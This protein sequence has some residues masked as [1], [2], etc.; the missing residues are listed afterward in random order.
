MLGGRHRRAD[1]APDPLGRPRH[2]GQ[3]EVGQQLDGGGHQEVV[4]TE[5][6]RAQ[7]AHPE[8]RRFD[9]DG[10]VGGLDVAPGAAS[11]ISSDL[12]SA[13]ST[14]ASTTRTAATPIAPQPSQTAS[15]VASAAPAP[16]SATAVATGAA[17]AWTSATG[18]SACAARRT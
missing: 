8:H 3:V 1:R 9:G 7:L 14:T 4:G 15:S 5:S 12:S 13:T 6:D 17:T 16:P 11:P 10:R 2:L 18:S